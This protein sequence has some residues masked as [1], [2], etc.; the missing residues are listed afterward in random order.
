MK[1]NSTNY[2]VDNRNEINNNQSEIFN[3]FPTMACKS[4]SKVE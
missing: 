4:S 1:K 2:D 3:D